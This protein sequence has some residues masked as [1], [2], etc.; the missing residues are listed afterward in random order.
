MQMQIT[1]FTVHKLRNEEWFRFHTEFWDWVTLCGTDVLEITRLE[2]PYRMLYKEVGR[3]LDVLLRD[4]VAVDLVS[5][6]QQCDGVFL[7]LRDTARSMQKVSDPIKQ[8]AALKVYAVIDKYTDTVRKGNQTA[9]TEA[10]DRLLDDLTPGKGSIDLSQELQLLNLGEWIGD[11]NTANK[12]YKQSLAERAEG[13]TLS[14]EAVR[15]QQVR[16]EMDYYYTHMINVIDA[17]LLTV[18]PAVDEKEKSPTEDYN[19]EPSTADEKLL[20]FAKALNTCTA[21]YQ[22][23]LKRN[24][25][26]GS[27]KKSRRAGTAPS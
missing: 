6:E 4:L 5:A 7:C 10:V 1:R 23:L 19:A 9:K 11:L 12:R 13:A 14:P 21:R 27:G 18:A 3:L 24:S 2:A 22:S 8:I 25:K 20:H 16:A 26:Y 17:R 15:L